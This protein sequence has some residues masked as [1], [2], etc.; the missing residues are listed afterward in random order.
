MYAQNQSQSEFESIQEKDGPRTR[1]Y[2]DRPMLF[3]FALS[4]DFVDVGCHF[5]ARWIL[6]VVLKSLNP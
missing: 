4:L 2:M 1:S 5:G 3:V 6:K